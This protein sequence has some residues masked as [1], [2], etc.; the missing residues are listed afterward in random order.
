MTYPPT[1][2]DLRDRLS[3]YPFSAQMTDTQL[4]MYIQTARAK[5]EIRIP[6]AWDPNSVPDYLRNA[7]GMVCLNLAVYYARA[8]VERDDTGGLPSALVSFGQ[9]V[10]SDLDD[11]ATMAWQSVG[12]VGVFDTREGEHSAG[13]GGGM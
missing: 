6:Q 10:N 5:I 8:D 13:G 2:R 12:V 11:L 7:L 1:V 9:M 4:D 3:V